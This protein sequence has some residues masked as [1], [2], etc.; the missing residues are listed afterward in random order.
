MLYLDIDMIVTGSLLP[1]WETD[2]GDSWCAAVVDPGVDVQE[3]S[4]KFDLKGKS[5][6]FNAGLILF[7]LDI[8][9]QEN[10]FEI[11]LET[12]K[13]KEVTINLNGRDSTTSA[14]GNSRARNSAASMTIMQTLSR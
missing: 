7:D 4:N 6:Y 10:L 14:R 12:L 1:L 13:E 5:N 3:F 8:V 2:L 11:A 9:R